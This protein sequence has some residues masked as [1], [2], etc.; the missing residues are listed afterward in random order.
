MVSN[1][2]LLVIKKV[3]K[4]LVL[5]WPFF[6]VAHLIIL[7]ENHCF[8]EWEN[9][10]ALSLSSSSLSEESINRFVSQRRCRSISP[11]MVSTKRTFTGSAPLPL[12]DSVASEGQ[13]DS[14][15]Y[16]WLSLLPYIRVY[17]C[18]GTYLPRI[19]SSSPT[20]LKCSVSYIKRRNMLFICF[21]IKARNP[22]NLPYIRCNTV[23]KKSRSLGSSESNSSSSWIWNKNRKNILQLCCTNRLSRAAN[24]NLEHKLLVDHLLAEGCL[25]VGR[26]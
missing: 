20:P 5:V 15:N 9:D 13:Y 7:V 26:F 22:K 24:T 12:I 14:I 17:E 10:S 4:S 18:H 8:Y 23:F 19:S 16:C 11:H 1:D 2:T 3:H 25:E 6:H 21:R